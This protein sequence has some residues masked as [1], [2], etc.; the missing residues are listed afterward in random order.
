V[1]AEFAR[2]ALTKA[3]PADRT[4]TVEEY[5]ALEAACEER[6]EYLDGCI[7]A[8][9]GASWEHSQIRINLLVTLRTALRGR[10]CRPGDNDLR[11]RI[12][13]T[14]LHTY[15]DAS[16]VCGDPHFDGRRPP[17]LLNPTVLF[18]VLSESTEAYDRGARL[19][20]YRQIPSLREYVLIAQ[21]QPEICVYRCGE[22]VERWEIEIYLGADRALAL[23]SLGI[24][25]PLVEIYRDVA[26]PPASRQSLTGE[27][28]EGPGG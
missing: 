28:E 5:L 19:L 13:S 9:A 23:E 14:G 7:T 27:R 12:E 3:I 22:A 17:A 2:G 20:H 1:T 26:F 25:I 11:V 21:D 4:W 16:V 10:K 24:E 18:E 15:P 8:M 6:H